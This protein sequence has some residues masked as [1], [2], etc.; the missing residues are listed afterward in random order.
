V[1]KKFDRQAAVER[2]RQY[3]ADPIKWGVFK[4]PHGYQRESDQSVDRALRQDA[5]RHIEAL[6]DE[7]MPAEVRQYLLALMDKS[8]RPRRP[9]RPQTKERDTFVWMA[10]YYAVFESNLRPT[11][12]DATSHV[13]CGCSIVAAALGMEESEVKRIY[14]RVGMP[15]L[16]G[17][18]QP[19]PVCVSEY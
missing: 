4:D 16:S 6:T 17:V 8:Y 18:L 15:A 14:L 3:L 12:N 2:V 5:C 1:G 13:E 7:Q 9:G 19:P 10:V 11:R